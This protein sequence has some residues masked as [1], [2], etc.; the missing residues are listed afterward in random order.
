MN[1]I[2]GVKTSYKPFWYNRYFVLPSFAG[3]AVMYVQSECLK[4]TANLLVDFFNSPAPS[5]MQPIYGK[6]EARSVER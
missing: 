4:I 2:W 1:A 5:A 6:G 3:E